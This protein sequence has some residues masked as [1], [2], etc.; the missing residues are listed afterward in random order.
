ML[1]KKAVR[2]ARVRFKVGTLSRYGATG[3]WG[4][5]EIAQRIAAR[6]GVPVDAVVASNGLDALKYG[7]RRISAYKTRKWI[8]ST[9][10]PAPT[11]V[12]NLCDE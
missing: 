8:E 11:F 9:Y 2:A 7:T 1:N 4:D 3:L 12:A 5:I 6:T 10:G